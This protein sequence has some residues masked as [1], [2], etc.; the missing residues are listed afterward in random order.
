MR[1]EASRRR[2]IKYG[3]PLPSA[4]LTRRYCFVHEETVIRRGTLNAFIETD[5]VRIFPALAG[6]RLSH[7]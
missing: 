2:R 6:T 7:L 4:T 3:I 1:D 5:L